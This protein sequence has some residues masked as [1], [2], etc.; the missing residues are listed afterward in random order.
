MLKKELG[1]IKRHL[2]IRKKIFG[3]AE[4]PRLSVHRSA[5]N[6]YVQVID[7]TTARTLLSFSTADKTFKEKLPKKG[8][9]AAAEKLGQFY[10]PLLKQKGIRHIA[11][12]RAGSLYHGRIKALAESLRQGGIEF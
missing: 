3:T 4:R 9:V 1:R 2:S 8:K 11:F 10:A 7:D 6:L 12:D 5:K